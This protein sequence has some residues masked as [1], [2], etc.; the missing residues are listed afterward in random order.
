MLGLGIREWLLIRTLDTNKPLKGCFQMT[1]W[2]LGGVKT[3]R[4]LE[5]SFQSTYLVS[6]PLIKKI[7]QTI[8]EALRSYSL[9]QEKYSY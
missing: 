3:K 7:S 2:N 4:L 6:T 9:D 1:T 8:A 5:F